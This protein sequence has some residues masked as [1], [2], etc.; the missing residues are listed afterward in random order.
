MVRLATRMAP[1]RD[2]GNKVWLSEYSRLPSVTWHSA[3]SAT[4]HNIRNFRYAA[5][6]SVIPDWYSSRFSLSDVQSTDLILSYWGSCHIAYV[7]LSF[8]LSPRRRIAFSVETRRHQGQAWSAWRG[9]LH[10]YPVIYVA[11]DERDLIGQ[12]LCTRKE[13]F[14]RC[15]SLLFMPLR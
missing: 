11:G 7:F 5:D 8:T 2:N 13:P 10:A 6:G 14:T 4:L 12:C 3:H 9:F 15:L 1:V